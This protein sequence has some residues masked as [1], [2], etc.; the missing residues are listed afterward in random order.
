MNPLEMDGNSLAPSLLV[1]AHCMT[2]RRK[3]KRID[4]Q[5]LSAILDD[6]FRELY[7]KPLNNTSYL[8]SMNEIT[9]ALNTSAIPS[10]VLLHSHYFFL[11]VRNSIQS[12]LQ[13][14]L[15]T[16]L[17]QQEMFVL[18]NC[19]VLLET[20]VKKIYDV[21]KLL[22]WINDNAFVKAV[23]DTLTQI[24]KMPSAN[25]NKRLIRQIVRLVN[26]FGIIQER[27]PWHLHENLFI[28]LLQPAVNCLTSSTYVQLFQDLKPDTKSLSSI[29]KLY[30]IKCPYFLERYNGKLNLYDV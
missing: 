22:P 11:L 8:K 28:S 23:A 10:L 29:Q 17:N 16:P 18:R 9:D 24:N 6:L 13:K 30:L 21:S 26:I 14:S 27:L 2:I 25:H 3:K 19:T 20:L 15:T 1:A 7:Y 4:I 12:L 5:E